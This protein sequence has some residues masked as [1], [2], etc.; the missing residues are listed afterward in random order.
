NMPP[1]RPSLARNSSMICWLKSL[2]ILGSFDNRSAFD[3]RPVVLVVHDAARHDWV[4]DVVAKALAVRPDAI[5]VD[6]GIPAPPE[7]ATHVA[8]HGISRVSAQ[9]AAE[10]LVQ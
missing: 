9:A 1:T 8:T 3:D 6:T 4:R 2:G 10:W 5:V 7:G